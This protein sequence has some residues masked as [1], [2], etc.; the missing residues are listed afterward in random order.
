MRRMEANDAGQMVRM[1][2]GGEKA[3]AGHRQLIAAD[4]QDPTDG[5]QHSTLDTQQL[6]PPSHTQRPTAGSQSLPH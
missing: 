2:Y 6:A 1:G 4:T 5:T 3:A